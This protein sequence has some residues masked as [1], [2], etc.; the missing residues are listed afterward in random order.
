MFHI[1]DTPSG[2]DEL[3]QETSKFNSSSFQK[4]SSY[5]KS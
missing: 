5:L 1:D 3:T 2:I 4:V